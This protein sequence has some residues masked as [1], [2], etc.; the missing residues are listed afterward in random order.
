[1][2]NPVPLV[3][4]YATTPKSS[5]IVATPSGVAFSGVNMGW[6]RQNGGKSVVIFVHGLWLLDNRPWQHA[7][8][9]TY[10]PKLVADDPA[11]AEHDIY[12]F[13]Y[14]AGIA[15]KNYS[16][17]HVV[18]NLQTAL[19]GDGVDKR[20]RLIFV[21]HSLGGIVVR[22][23]LVR[24]DAE[25]VHSGMQIDLLLVASPSRGSRYADGPLAALAQGA[26]VEHIS[27]LRGL[28]KNGQLDQLFKDFNALLRRSNSR[29]AIHGRE[30][31]EQRNF[32]WVLPPIV[33]TDSGACFF[34]DALM[35]EGSDHFSIAC[36]SSAEAKQHVVLRQFIADGPAKLD[37][38][39]ADPNAPS[40]RMVSLRAI[41][42]E[43]LDK[44]FRTLAPDTTSVRIEWPKATDQAL[45]L[46][47][48]ALE[49]LDSEAIRLYGADAIS[50]EGTT[51]L[52]H[53]RK[54]RQEME[55]RLPQFLRRCARLSAEDQKQAVRS[56]L[57][58]GHYLAHSQAFHLCTWQKMPELGL[59]PPESVRWYNVLA[60]L[61]ETYGRLLGF[62]SAAIRR[63]RLTH[64]G[65]HLINDNGTD[66]L[67]VL[68]PNHALEGYGARCGFGF[69]S[70][71][72]WFLPQCELSLPHDALPEVY[73]GDLVFSVVIGSDGAEV[74]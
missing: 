67:W 62:E 38:A 28:R 9:G 44:L 32:L 40:I 33:T 23:L 48:T 3:A 61:A 53:A 4:R 25:Y 73:D 74:R 34:A 29:L 45:R 63:G 22:R 11:L 8:S 36:P 10:W 16:I 56:Y 24:K 50:T 37:E 52:W 2:R 69:R 6:L 39:V 14:L 47:E 68:G 71:A 26:G 20:R 46:L 30:L 13:D 57:L 19:A 12:V 72:Q 55:A 42:E 7:K 35:I 65:E 49:R 17:D 1:M 18:E 41:D 64:I 27:V 66:Y 60:P 54:I 58:F 15:S 59:H 43:S 5:G 21:C 70:T 31:L 51:A